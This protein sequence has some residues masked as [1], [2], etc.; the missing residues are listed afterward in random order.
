ML[1]RLALS[2]GAAAAAAPLT[3]TISTASATCVSPRW[4]SSVT[5]DKP[6]A[7]DSNPFTSAIAKTLRE[8]VFS[9]DFAAVKAA[10]PKETELLKKWRTVDGTPAKSPRQPAT[11]GTADSSDVEPQ[12]AEGARN[13]A[14]SHGTTFRDSRPVDPK[15]SVECKRRRLIYQSRYRGMVEM[16]LIFGHFARCKLETLD[17]SMLDEYDML[18]KQLDSELFRWLVMGV[19]A[20]EGVAKLRCFGELRRFIKEERTA[21]LGSN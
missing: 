21:L 19:D 3:V 6:G 5:S 8:K 15:E 14:M 13:V 2:R 16:D 1:P 9:Q 4:C 10:S 12:I 7:A 20:P 11:P 17:A 18:L